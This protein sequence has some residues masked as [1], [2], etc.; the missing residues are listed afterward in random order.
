MLTHSVVI[1]SNS[2]LLVSFHSAC[3]RMDVHMYYTDDKSEK[4]SAALKMSLQDFHLV[5]VELLHL[6]Y[7]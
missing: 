3:R 7:A 6:K 2:Y 5:L 4:R 1:F